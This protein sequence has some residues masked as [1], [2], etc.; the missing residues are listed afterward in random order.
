M[1]KHQRILLFLCTI[2]FASVSSAQYVGFGSVTNGAADCPGY[3]TYHVTNLTDSGPGS[4][5]DA[6]SAGCRLVVFDV[7]GEIELTEKLL[8]QHSYLT[9][10]GSSA[11]SPGITIYMPRI[12]MAIEAWSSIGD[13]HDIIIHHLRLVGAGGDLEAADLLEL[14]GMDA[15]VYNVVLDHITAVA[16]SDGAFDIYGEVRDVTLSYNLIR[17]MVKPA[18]LSRNV[19]DRENITLHANVFARNNERQVR[20]RYNNRNLDITNNVVYGWGFFEGGATGLDITSDSGYSPS[21]NIENN[22]YHYVQGNGSPDDA[23]RFNSRTFPGDIYFAG[24]DFPAGEDD[25]ISTSGRTPIPA[26][27]QVDLRPT[28]ELAGS[29]VACAGTV[30]PT[31]EESDLLD[32]I[33]GAIGGSGGSCDDSGAPKRPSAPGNLQVQ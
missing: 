33:R 3:E 16:A 26:Y 4:F 14:D 23:V 31:R 19:Q 22:I 28:S 5:R 25:A 15:V 12:R 2:F 20:I 8:I 7:A 21:I 9:V 10:D 13:A 17:D 11:P 1:A 18:H 27:A 29:V 32:E 24:N 30:Y 6:V